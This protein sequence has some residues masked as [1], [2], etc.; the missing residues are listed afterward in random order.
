MKTC[1]DCGSKLRSGICTNCNEELYINDY[2]MPE[3]D[4]P[5]ECSKEWHEKVEEQRRILNP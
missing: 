4:E 5:I 3:M 1:E 2:Q